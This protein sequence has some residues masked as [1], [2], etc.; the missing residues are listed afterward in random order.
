MAAQFALPVYPAKGASA[1]EPAQ[2]GRVL[3]QHQLNIGVDDAFFLDGP[4]RD[5]DAIR[6]SDVGALAEIRRDQQ[7]LGAELFRRL[8]HVLGVDLCPV[9]VEGQRRVWYGLERGDAAV[10]WRA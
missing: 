3:A 4:D 6:V 2:P 1:L 5:L 10:V 9:C 7:A 8:R